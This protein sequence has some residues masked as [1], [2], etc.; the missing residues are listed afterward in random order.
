MDKNQLESILFQG[1]DETDQEKKRKL[2]ESIADEDQED[3]NVQT[4]QYYLGEMYLTGNGVKKDTEKAC[5]YLKNPAD[6][7]H[8]SACFY[9]GL[10]LFDQ[11]DERAFDYLCDSWKRSWE[12]A[13]MRL[14]QYRNMGDRY[15]TVAQLAQKAIDSCYQELQGKLAAGEDKSG[16]NSL[17]LALYYIYELNGHQLENL[18]SAQKYLRIA[19]EHGSSLAKNI[20][21]RTAFKNIVNPEASAR[22][23]DAGKD[24]GDCGGNV[25]PELWE[26]LV[27]A[28]KVNDGKERFSALKAIADRSDSENSSRK[29]VIGRAQCLVAKELHTGKSVPRDDKMALAYAKKAENLGQGEDHLLGALQILTGDYTEGLQTLATGLI[30]GDLSC[31]K[32]LGWLMGHRGDFPFKAELEKTVNVALKV[33]NDTLESS[34]GDEAARALLGAGDTILFMPYFVQKDRSNCVQLYRKAANLGRRCDAEERMELYNQVADKEK[35]VEIP[36]TEELNWD[37]REWYNALVKAA[38]DRIAANRQREEDKKHKLTV[39]KVVLYLI[40]SLFAGTILTQITGIPCL[41]IV[42]FAVLVALKLNDQKKYNESK[43]QDETTKTK[44]EQGE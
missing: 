25:N 43:K 16:Q 33:I 5:F 7:Q 8:A 31:S 30:C 2:F 10:L 17:A 3:E 39:G 38:Q 41:V 36:G 44:E 27:S 34:S 11:G 15:Q 13:L 29:A 23:D 6:H 40:I 35:F 12:P 21:S 18:S 19:V 42:V 14:E 28:L 32:R 37:F 20:L 9:Y 4:A 1:M 24:Y 26:K 22:F